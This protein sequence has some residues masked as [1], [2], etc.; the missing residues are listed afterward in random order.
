MPGCRAGV[1]FLVVEVDAKQKRGRT[2]L[3]QNGGLAGKEKMS[4]KKI[5]RNAGEKRKGAR[6]GSP[7]FKL[8]TRLGRQKI[9]KI[10]TA[11]GLG[12]KGKRILLSA[13]KCVLTEELRDIPP[14]KEKNL[15]K[16]EKK[17]GTK[18]EGGV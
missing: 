3:A 2:R 8:T 4:T 6:G 18:G 12:R 11:A 9:N 14:N 13:P 17:G 16:S 1:D 10:K 7:G 5:T 15:K